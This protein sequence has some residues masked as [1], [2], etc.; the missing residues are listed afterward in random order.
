[1]SGAVRADDDVDVL[2]V[3]AG[4][5]GSSIARLIAQQRPS[6]SILMV[7]LG[8][9][10]TAVPGTHLTTLPY[11][12]H[13]Q[14]LAGSQGP[15]RGRE[16]VAAG[17][18]SPPDPATAGEA[19]PGLHR[20]FPSDSSFPAA[21]QASMVG[22]MGA[23]WGGITPR[24]SG[25]ERIDFI[26]DGVWDTAVQ[27]AERVLRVDHTLFAGGV[28]GQSIRTRTAEMFAASTP[29]PRIGAHPLAARRQDDGAFAITGTADVL[30]PI[31]AQAERAGGRCEI[32]SSTLCVRLV[33]DGSR[34]AGAIMESRTTGHR[35]EVRAQVVVVAGD[36]YRTPQLLWASG[37]RPSA[38]GAHLMD[39]PVSNAAVELHPDLMAEARARGDASRSVSFV[40]FAGDAHPFH[41]VI[42]QGLVNLVPGSWVRMNESDG[43]PVNAVGLSWLGRTFPRMSNRIV[44]TDSASDWCGMPAM[45]VE[46]SLSDR[47]QGERERGLDTVQRLAAALGTPISGREPAMRALGGSLHA[48]GTARMGERDD[49]ASVCDPTSRVWGFD[50]LFLGGNAVLPRAT[51]VNPTLTSV[52]LATLAVSR[53]L[54]VLRQENR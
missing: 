44:F 41:G 6:S 40:S 16:R 30:A 31:M 23:Y 39:H 4:P 45:S 50:N 27:T 24:P 19:P 18:F 28:I 12:E 15:D 5:V 34:V 32:R 8:P 17:L 33:H 26:G 42:L 35:Y 2:I 36:V 13:A 48:S 38:L 7:D 9:A 54:G 10:L 52:A 11:E 29:G 14:V 46:F 43:V 37:I 22:G 20:P 53:I 1:M 25:S 47:E 51:T 21:G 3:G 49:G